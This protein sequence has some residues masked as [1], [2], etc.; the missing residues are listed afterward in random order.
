[1]SDEDMPLPRPP[2]ESHSKERSKKR[3]APADVHSNAK[4]GPGAAGAA[5]APSG[6]QTSKTAPRYVFD[7]SLALIVTEAASAVAEGKKEVRLTPE[8]D[9]VSVTAVDA[10]GTRF[11]Q[12]FLGTNNSRCDGQHATMVVDPCLLCAVLKCEMEKALI[13][14]FGD[15]CLDVS[16]FGAVDDEGES[17]SELLQMDLTQEA[18]DL[19]NAV[20]PEIHA[21]E[22]V[23]APIETKR[24]FALTLPVRRLKQLLRTASAVALGADKI[25]FSISVLSNEALKIEETRVQISTNGKATTRDSFEWRTPIGGG[26]NVKLEDAMSTARVVPASGKKKL[27]SLT[28]SFS[29]KS[30]SAAAASL[31]R[32]V[33]KLEFDKSGSHVNMRYVLDAETRSSICIAI[34]SV[35]TD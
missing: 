28:E 23:P 10:A 8:E 16:F 31:T 12:G 5:G 30:V 21:E 11:M 13:I 15:S 22:E 26:L 32:S 14:T 25:R 6:D 24:G 20:V 35:T 4:R 33:V 18:A 7:P 27:F 19:T 9:G 17:A 34:G 1:M 2:R 3:A 29:L